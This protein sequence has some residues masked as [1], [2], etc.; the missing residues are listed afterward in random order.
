[1]PLLPRKS[2]LAIA[3]VIDIALH[4]RGQPVAAKALAARHGLPPRHLEPVL[5][6]LVR[7]GILKGRRGPHGGYDL[8]REQRHISADDILRAA[9][10][11]DDEDA[12]MMGSALLCGV[13]APA[14]A[15]A[16][17]TFSGALARITVEDLTRAAA[18]LP[19]DG[20]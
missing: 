18:G 3:A 12:P 9:G 7:A 4:A 20:E 8:A 16:E 13:I 5:Q 15:Q 14:I 17:Q 19:K 10:A 2:V 1:M 6:A 11:V